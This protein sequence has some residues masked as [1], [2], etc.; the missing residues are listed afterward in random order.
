MVSLNVLVLLAASDE[1]KVTVPV[2]AEKSAA[3]VDTWVTVQV[4]VVSEAKAP[5]L[6]VR[7]MV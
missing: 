4:M 7:V 6:P 5:P 3:S 2:T 1:V